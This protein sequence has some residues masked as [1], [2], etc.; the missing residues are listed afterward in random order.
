MRLI[1]REFLPGSTI[2]RRADADLPTLTLSSSTLYEGQTQ[3][4]TVGTFTP[5]NFTGT[6]GAVSLANI[7][8]SGAVQMNVDGRTLEYGATPIDRDIDLVATFDASYDDDTGTKTFSFILDVLLVGQP[9][10]GTIDG[11]FETDADETAPILTSPVG[12]KTGQTTADGGVTTDEGNGTLYMVTTQS[13]TQPSAAQIAAGTDHADAAADFDDSLAVSAAGV[14]AFSVT[15][16]TASTAYYN[17]YVHVDAA[18]NT[19]SVVSSAEFTTSA[20]SAWEPSDDATLYGKM[21]AWFDASDAATI[22]ATGAKVDSWTDK[23]NGNVATAVSTARPDTGT[24]SLNGLNVIDFDGSNDVLQDSTPTDIGSGSL[25]I[26]M[27]GMVIPDVG[28]SGDYIAAYGVATAGQVL[29]ITSG[30]NG[31]TPDLTARFF[32][33][34]AESGVSFTEGTPMMFLLQRAAGDTHAATVMRVNGS[35]TTPVVGSSA[36]SLNFPASGKVLAVGGI[37]TG[38]AVAE[39]GVAE[40]F[41]GTT[42]MTATE[43][44]KMEGYLAHKWGQTALLPGGHPYKSTAP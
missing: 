3:G 18:G 13:A 23:K 27:M 4:D 2:I 8:P 9:A 37:A 38:G 31:N 20:A 40:I 30:K 22:S 7:S 17:H 36:N 6:A 39:V 12:T 19:S 15:G 16:L 34:Y 29:S 32:N 10:G 11:V 26:W 5:G 28:Q 25:A 24:R 41:F 43:Y 44:Q 33:G 14:K 1:S 35:A 21:F 42:A